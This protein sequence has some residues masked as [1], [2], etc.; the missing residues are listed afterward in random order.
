[1]SP[2]RF[3]RPIFGQGVSNGPKAYYPSV[4]YD[5]DEFSG[6]GDLAK[7]KMWYGTSG[8][9]TAL[10]TSADGISWTNPVVVMTDGYH[11]T[12]ETMRMDFPELTVVAL[13]VV[14]RCTIACGTGTLARISMMFLP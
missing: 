12:V 10:A 7:Y 4:L 5:P 6:H 11:A 1:M 14:A 3:E 9:Q 13:P 8:S 2:I